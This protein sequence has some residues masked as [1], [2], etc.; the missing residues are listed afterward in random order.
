MQ[1]VHFWRTAA[2][3]SLSAVAQGFLAT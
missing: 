2:D 1:I 3:W